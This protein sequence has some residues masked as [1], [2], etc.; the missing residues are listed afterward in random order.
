MPVSLLLSNAAPES[1]AHKLH[2]CLSESETWFQGG[3]RSLRLRPWSLSL[4]LEVSSPTKPSLFSASG[5]TKGGKK[6][7]GVNTQ[8]PVRH[9]DLEMSFQGKHRISPF[10]IWA[11]Q[12]WLLS[13]VRS[14]VLPLSVCASSSV[15]R[16]SLSPKTDWTCITGN[17]VRCCIDATNVDR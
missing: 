13:E 15:K 5:L 12:I 17:T 8:Q 10:C 11:L 7:G 16:T 2:L 4:V 14:L 9:L 6:R 3:S 1:K